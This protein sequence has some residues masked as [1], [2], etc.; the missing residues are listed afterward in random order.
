M[1]R[2][3]AP[4][5]W[6]LTYAWLLLAMALPSLAW[7]GP[8][9]NAT[10]RP[11][12]APC[13]DTTVELAHPTR[14]DAIAW[15]LD[16]LS[17]TGEPE[18]IAAGGALA[19]TWCLAAQPHRFWVVD[20]DGET[21]GAALTLWQDGAPL[22]Q[23]P[24]KGT[25]TIVWTPRTTPS[26]LHVPSQRHH[27]TTPG[28]VPAPP[29]RSLLAL[30]IAVVLVG[31]AYGRAPRSPDAGFS[32]LCLA[33]FLITTAWAVLWARGAGLHI[34]IDEV[35]DL[36]WALDI[37]HRGLQPDV[38]P[39]VMGTGNLSTLW[40]HLLTGLQAS[41][42]FP[43]ARMTQ[44]LALGIA[45]TLTGALA[46]RTTQPAALPI[47]AA[48]AISLPAFHEP[49]QL[50]THGNFA[51][52]FSL[53][54]LWS[55]VVLYGREQPWHAVPMMFW[56]SMGAQLYPPAT[57]TTLA[58]CTFAIRWGRS[59]PPTYAALS[60]VAAALPWW[61]TLGDWGSQPP[62]TLASGILPAL[63]V[64]IALVFPG[65]LRRPVGA[66]GFLALALDDRS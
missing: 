30:S 8:N 49:S 10:D 46:A 32:G 57:F 14:P 66:T 51:M 56:L 36:G 54:A 4:R 1:T 47:A 23:D 55:A 20:A 7:A 27:L 60:L 22:H 52:A 41:L 18:P 13:V 59:I 44:S 26:D 29:W 35:R 12:Q 65:H 3:R 45:A 9:A 19:A 5:S 62:T 21:E 48:W 39:E 61:P 16:R 24:I 34:P 11:S 25:H 28:S 31:T 17:P 15:R 43:S 2:T 6:A 33:T 42:G 37:L 40:Y 64:W 53:L 63:A 50:F 38:G 58:L